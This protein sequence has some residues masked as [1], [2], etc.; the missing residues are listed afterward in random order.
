MTV[1]TLSTLDSGE[2]PAVLSAVLRQLHGPDARLEGWTADFRFTEHGKQ[3]VVRY[4]LQ[5][6]L[7]G[8]AEVQRDQWVGKFYDRDQD[9]RMVAAVLQALAIGDC[10]ARGGFSVPRVVTYDDP[11]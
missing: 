6:R 5:A 10:G 7:A 3:R 8:A 11:R 9:A 1:P 2:T 4:D